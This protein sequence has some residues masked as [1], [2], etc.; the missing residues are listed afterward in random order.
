[1]REV[2]QTLS[3]QPALD[4]QRQ[5]QRHVYW[6]ELPQLIQVRALEMRSRRRHIS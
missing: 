6:Y 2:D 5:N 1:M 4:L 3:D